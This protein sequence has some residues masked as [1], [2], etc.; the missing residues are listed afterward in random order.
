M[1]IRPT[2]VTRY[3]DHPNVDFKG[4]PLA[5]FMPY[6]DHDRM[7]A[8]LTCPVSY[9]EEEPGH[10]DDLRIQY[11]ARVK[12]FFYPTD[13][14]ISFAVKVW[15]AVLQGYKKRNPNRT[16]ADD[17]FYDLCGQLE[18]EVG[19][20]SAPNDRLGCQTYIVLL[21]TPGGGK[22]R[23]LMALFGRLPKILYHRLFGIFQVPAVFI[24][25]PGKGADSKTLPFSI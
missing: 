4:N 20:V 14:Q 23:T 17:I 5:E 3:F 21:G 13:Q 11:I 2:E 10:D 15:N 19:Y 18:S 8:M 12:E 22:T 9:H 1:V 24:S 7:R 25:S 16:S 6:L